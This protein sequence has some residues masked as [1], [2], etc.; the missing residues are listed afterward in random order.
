MDLVF[1]LVLFLR[2]KA[3]LCIPRTQDP[4]KVL[5]VCLKGVRRSKCVLPMQ[6]NATFKNQTDNL[7]NLRKVNVYM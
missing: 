5:D 4:A 1:C 3:L 6:P 2:D 7:T